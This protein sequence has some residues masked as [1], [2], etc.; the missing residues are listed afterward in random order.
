M[1]SKKEVMLLH[2]GRAWDEEFVRLTAS[3]LFMQTEG[4]RCMEIIC[5]HVS[6]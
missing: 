1:K 4:K 5:I 6:K 3:C 2:S